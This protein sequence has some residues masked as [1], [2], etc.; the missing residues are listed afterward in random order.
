ML[1]EKKVA[2]YTALTDTGNVGP[3]NTD[4]TLKYSKVFTNIGNAYNPATGNM[5]QVTRAH[6]VR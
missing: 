1:T 4:T 3:Y 2:F 5:L 6:A